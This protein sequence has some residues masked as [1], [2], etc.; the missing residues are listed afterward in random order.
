MYNFAALV[1]HIEISTFFN[2]CELHKICLHGWHWFDTFILNAQI[3]CFCGEP[4]VYNPPIND[5]YL[6]TLIFFGT[7]FV[8]TKINN[9]KTRK[10]ASR[11]QHYHFL[12][13]IALDIDQNTA[14][15]CYVLYDTSYVE[16]ISLLFQTCSAKFNFVADV[17]WDIPFHEKSGQ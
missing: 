16:T 8:S 15:S 1:S 11:N 2:W 14:K 7:T 3:W 13:T 6:H 10:N 4:I 17:K 12:F 5:R 9:F